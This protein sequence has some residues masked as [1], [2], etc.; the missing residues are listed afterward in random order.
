MVFGVVL[1]GAALTGFVG[2]CLCIA[3]PPESRARGLAIGSVS[4]LV[5]GVILYGVCILLLMIARNRFNQGP[6]L[7]LVLMFGLLSVASALTG[8]V[9]FVQ[10]MKAVAFFFRRNFA[11]FSRNK[12]FAQSANGFLILSFVSGGL[13]LVLLG[14]AFAVRDPQAG[15]AVGCFGLI[16]AVVGII[17]VLWFLRLLAT[18]PGCIE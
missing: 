2:M 3:A 11:G 4:A 17:L 12:P 18:A 6:A 10:F 13:Y 15:M 7:M 1:L 5:L 16:I 14:F 8:V 9:L